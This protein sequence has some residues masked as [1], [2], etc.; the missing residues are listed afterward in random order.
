MILAST[1]AALAS[2]V[3]TAALDASASAHTSAA[4]EATNAIAAIIESTVPSAVASIL[5]SG[6]TTTT[7]VSAIPAVDL[8]GTIEVTAAFF[9]GLAG[10]LAGVKHRLD[11]VGVLA[12]GI[13][14]G[15][16]G[17]IIRDVLLQKYGVYA[18]QNPRL[19]LAAT[20]A[21]LIAFYFSSGAGRFKGL[22]LMVDTISLGLFVFIGADKAL[23]ASEPAV[24]A[25]LLGTITGVG[26]GVVR[27]LLLDVVPRILRPGNF[28]ALAAVNGSIV[29]VGATA[30]LGVVK[31]VAGI[32]SLLVVVALRYLSLRLGWTTP[33]P[34]DLTPRVEQ[35]PEPLRGPSHLM[36]KALTRIDRAILP[37]DDK[38]RP[39]DPR[40]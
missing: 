16:G 13:T 18:F 2:S 29:Y 35:L 37:R 22:L 31:P 20:L 5:P 38:K 7:P 17:G 10:G 6:V 26:G 28:Y 27:D 39:P 4:A 36:H 19:L 8:P 40:A 34:R 11:L 24:T 21:G 3:A 9:G 25:I 14:V 12:L 33:E 30:W 23:L 32:L 15:L 1:A